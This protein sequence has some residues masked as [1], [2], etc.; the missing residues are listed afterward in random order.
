MCK[1]ETETWNAYK[2]A[3]PLWPR[4]NKEKEKGEDSGAQL[5]DK[6]ALIEVAR[7]FIR[8]RFLSVSSKI[9]QYSR[10]LLVCLHDT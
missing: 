3:I 7:C 2:E 6:S 4:T 8:V 9:A 10:N 1:C 5:I